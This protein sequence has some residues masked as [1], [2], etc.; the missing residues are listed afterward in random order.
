MYYRVG[1]LF[2]RDDSVEKRYRKIDRNRIKRQIGIKKV[3]T[4]INRVRRR[5]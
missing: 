1:Q 4:E 3:M 5:K 2:A